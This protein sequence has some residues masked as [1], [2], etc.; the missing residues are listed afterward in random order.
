[1]ISAYHECLGRFIRAFAATE[2][3]MN[4]ALREFSKVTGP[5]ARA[6]FSGTRAEAAKQYITRIMDAE[7]YRQEIK[8]ELKNVFNQLGLINSARNE[9]LHYGTQFEGDQFIV[10]N[11][12]KAHLPSRIS[13]LPV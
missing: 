6:I 13:V 10:T 3:T 4:G 1:D 2:G 9:I 5:V 7:H 8:D 12:A 11:A